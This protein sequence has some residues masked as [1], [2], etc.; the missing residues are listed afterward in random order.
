MYIYAYTC[1]MRRN[2]LKIGGC[3]LDSEHTNSSTRCGVFL[4]N[5]LC[6]VLIVSCHTFHRIMLHRFESSCIVSPSYYGPS[7][8][9]T[10]H[11]DTACR[12]SHCV[13]SRHN[14]SRLIRF[15]CSALKRHCGLQKLVP[16]HRCRCTRCYRNVPVM[17]VFSCW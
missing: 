5:R 8:R 6:R 2:S 12:K 4:V 1:R 16:K 17:M 14:A 11:R 13:A 15:R 10:P 7:S 9:V 3:A